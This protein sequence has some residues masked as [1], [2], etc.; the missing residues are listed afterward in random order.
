MS[1]PLDWHSGVCISLVSRDQGGERRQ[2]NK[3]NRAIM[4]CHAH[5]VWVLSCR[6]FIAFITQP[7]FNN[8]WTSLGQCVKDLRVFVMNICIIELVSLSIG[9][10]WKDD[11]IKGAP[12]LYGRRT[13]VNIPDIVN[14]HGYWGTFVRIS[15]QM[16]M[17]T[18]KFVFAN[19]AHILT[20][21]FPRATERWGRQEWPTSLNFLLQTR[22]E[23]VNGV[24]WRML[25]KMPL[26]S[27]S[28]II[29]LYVH[30]VTWRLRKSSYSDSE[31]LGGS[32][33]S[34]TIWK[35]PGDASF[36]DKWRHL[37]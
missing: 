20:L 2:G 18:F 23:N 29:K 14:C 22:E 24:Q 31:V 34:C 3:P 6:T 19:F 15:R 25:T 7:N 27:G 35:L 10:D 1:M 26:Y 9:L 11:L 33:R 32:L 30:Q 16:V 37:K 28:V 8:T 12:A 13:A 21:L 36:S 4:G 17:A 5:W